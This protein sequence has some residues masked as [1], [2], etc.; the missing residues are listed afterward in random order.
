MEN[1]LVKLLVLAALIQ[2]GISLS[3]LPKILSHPKNGK[4]LTRA[5]TT[6]DWKPISAFPEEARKFRK[7]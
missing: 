4:A 6:L 5:I 2:F 1:H 3:D 7:H